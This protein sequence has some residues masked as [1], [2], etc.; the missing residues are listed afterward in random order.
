[1]G[2]YLILSAETTSK[3]LACASQHPEESTAEVE[4]KFLTIHN[5]FGGSGTTKKKY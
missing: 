5:T 2:R 3:L 1:M 4:L